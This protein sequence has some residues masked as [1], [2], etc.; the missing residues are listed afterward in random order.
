MRQGFNFA[1]VKVR[2]DGQVMARRLER[3]K[4]VEFFIA[5]SHLCVYLNVIF[6]GRYQR[7]ERERETERD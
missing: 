4:T 7:T 6:P 3:I 1:L 5:D 2:T